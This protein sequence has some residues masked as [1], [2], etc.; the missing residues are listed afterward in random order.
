M[1]DNGNLDRE[2]LR[3]VFVYLYRCWI[4]KGIGEVP[5]KLALSAEDGFL[6]SPTFAMYF[7]LAALDEAAH[8]DLCSR[9][10]SPVLVI[11]P[12][13]PVG[14]LGIS[15][16][17]STK[18]L[19]SPFA[20]VLSLVQPRLKWLHAHKERGLSLREAYETEEHGTFAI[21][22]DHK[23][24]RLLFQPEGGDLHGYAVVKNAPGDYFF[25][26]SRSCKQEG[27]RTATGV[28]KRCKHRTE[29][30]ES[31]NI[32]LIYQSGEALLLRLAVAG[33]GYK[34]FPRETP[35]PEPSFP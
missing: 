31:L 1:T 21:W 16:L 22:K 32:D 15:E 18:G 20:K 8:K 3:E 4:Q 23:A 25:H 10:G 19:V 30:R 5:S 9:V 13:F 29:N 33:A 7:T 35:E 17:T 34:V 2:T 12:S 27:Q 11:A 28:Y 26:R 14:A 6:L 24:S